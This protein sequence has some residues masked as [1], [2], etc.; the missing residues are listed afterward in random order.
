MRECFYSMMGMPS[1]CD[2]SPQGAQLPTNP[3]ATPKVYIARCR[4]EEGIAK[5]QPDEQKPDIKAFAADKLAIDIEVKK[6]IVTRRCKSS[7]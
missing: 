6:A 5:S 1:A 4:R 7:R 3:K 2:G